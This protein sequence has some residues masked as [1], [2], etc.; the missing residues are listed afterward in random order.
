VFWKAHSPGSTSAGQQQFAI[1]GLKVQSVSIT[2]YICLSDYPKKKK[3]KK[4]KKKRKNQ[5]DIYEKKCPRDP[6]ADCMTRM[7]WCVAGMNS[8]NMAL[9]TGWF[10]PLPKPTSAE[11]IAI[12]TKV[13]AS[14]PISPAI[15]VIMSVTLNASRRPSEVCGHG[16]ERCADHQARVFGHGQERDALDSELALHGGLDVAYSLHP[17]LKGSQ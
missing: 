2:E 7:F 15:A 17:E 12:P 1:N 9:S 6:N 4:K 8:R 10:P 3:K 16:P 5:A 11:R 14:A 13:G